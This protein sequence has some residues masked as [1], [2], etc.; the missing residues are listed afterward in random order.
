MIKLLSFLTFSPPWPDAILYDSVAR[1]F[2]STGFFRYK[3]WGEYDPTYLVANFN[4]GPLYPALHALI[5]TVF[6]TTDSRLMMAVNLILLVL[7]TVNI[8]RILRLSGQQIALTVLILCNPL[9][10]NYVG[11]IRP[12]F[13]NLF[14]FTCI[15][16]LLNNSRVIAAG[17][18]LGLTALAHQFAIFFI[19]PAIYL[20]IRR[21]RGSLDII[22][23]III[24]GFSCLVTLA[25]YLYYIGQHWTAFTF[26]LFHNQMGE[27]MSSGVWPFVRS[28]V[29]PLFYPSI[30]QLTL[31][32]VVPRWFADG[33]HLALIFMVVALI[34]R[35]IKRASLS[36]STWDAL[37]IWLMLNLGCAVTT[38]SVF[39]T[40]FFSVATIA[41]LRD[42]YPEIPKALRNALCIGALLGISQQLMTSH[43]V[44]ER[45]CYWED[46]QIASA[47]LSDA[48]PQNAKVYVMAYPDPSVQLSNW[49]P[50]LDIRRYI[51][52]PTYQTAWQKIVAT[53]DYF[54]TSGDENFLTRFDHG[55]PLRNAIAN[56]QVHP[57]ACT[58]GNLRF[59]LYSRH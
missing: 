22:K 32:G 4:N 31:T 5:L 19:P 52:F 28:F 42:V 18:V 40:F 9:V 27:S 59:T 44:R 45:L 20:I 7:A 21:G 50:D 3:V 53:N 13:L 11:I 25:P 39:V 55:E 6:G 8:T 35:Q 58:S 37:V 34:G 47:C 36:S 16:R 41:L 56:H 49:R 24:L 29:T 26:Q 14:L 23:K 54:V 38:F 17:I 1:D 30:A 43:L 57:T 33:F 12:E 48:L 2:L 15:W 10:L 46:Y 51:D